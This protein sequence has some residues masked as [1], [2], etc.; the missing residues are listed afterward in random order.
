MAPKYRQGDIVLAKFPFAEQDGRYKDRPVLI[1]SNDTVNAIY[2][3]YVCLKITSSIKKIPEISI[4]ISNEDLEKPLHKDSEIR[5]MEITYIPES[6]IA[7]KLSA[8]K[9]KKLKK[10]LKSLKANIF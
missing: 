7:K 5:L 1:V 8:Y 6:I 3:A 9:Q 2:N 10:I 4:S